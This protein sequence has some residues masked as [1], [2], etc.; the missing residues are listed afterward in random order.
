MTPGL[1]I[2]YQ[3]S[4]RGLTIGAQTDY[5]WRVFPTGWGIDELRTSDVAQAYADGII[6]R[7]DHIARRDLT[8]RVHCRDSGDLS[9]LR[10]QQLAQALKAAWR[11][12][13]EDVTLSLRLMD[14]EVQ[15]IGRPRGVILDLTPLARGRIEATLRFTATDPR[16]FDALQQEQTVSQVV[17]GSGLSFPAS[18]PF[19]FG[20]ATSGGIILATNDGDTDAPWEATITGPLVNPVVINDATGE[21]LG[22]SAN[23]GLDLETGDTLVLDSRQRTALLNGSSRYDRLASSSRWWELPPGVTPIRLSATSGSG[24]LQLRWRS[25]YL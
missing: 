17:S 6:A 19:S 1:L 5:R 20:G 4:L 23:G 13:S 15:L 21:V 12:T 9:A 11:P 16:L 18:P 22:F 2:P 8:L 25:A 3:A 7:A 24:T 14:S 10:A